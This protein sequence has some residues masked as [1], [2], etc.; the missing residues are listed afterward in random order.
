M[1]VVTYRILLVKYGF[2]DWW[3]YVYE[4]GSVHSWRQRS[5]GTARASGWDACHCA[6][7]KGGALRGAKRWIAKQPTSQ[8]SEWVEVEA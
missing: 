1:A 7:T 8:K 5:D 3:A 6:L 2:G 4:P